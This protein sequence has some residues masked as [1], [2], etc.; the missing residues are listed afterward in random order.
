MGQFENLP[1]DV[2]WMIFKQVI[3]DRHSTEFVFCLEETYIYPIR[4]DSNLTIF[5]SSLAFLNKAFYNAIKCKIHVTKHGWWFIRGALLDKPE[6][7]HPFG[8]KAV[9]LNYEK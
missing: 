6:E 4:F 1:K 3:L 5:I 9:C 7:P 8:F 2:L